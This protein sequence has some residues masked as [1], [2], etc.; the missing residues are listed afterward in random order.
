MSNGQEVLEDIL[1]HKQIKI[2]KFSNKKNSSSCPAVCIRAA[3][4]DKNNENVSGLVFRDST[5]RACGA[6]TDERKRWR[7]FSPS[8]AFREGDLIVG[9][10]PACTSSTDNVDVALS[11]FTVAGMQMLAGHT[12]RTWL[13]LLGFPVSSLQLCS[14]TCPDLPDRWWTGEPVNVNDGRK[15]KTPKLPGFA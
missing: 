6:V 14:L 7:N 13:C 8:R 3:G 12:W 1:N 5:V 9:V 15:W 11:V 4:S 10:R 2:N